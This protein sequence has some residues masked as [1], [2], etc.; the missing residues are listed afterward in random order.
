MP[1]NTGDFTHTLHNMTFSQNTLRIDG[2]ILWHIPITTDDFITNT[3]HCRR[4]YTRF[5]QLC[6]GPRN[7]LKIHGRVLWHKPVTTDDFITKY[8]SLP[9]TLYTFYTIM[10]KS[11]EYTKNT[12]SCRVP[13]DREKQGKQGKW[14]KQIPCR[15]KSGNLKI[16]FSIRENTGNLKIS[17]KYQGKHREFDFTKNK[18]YWKCCRSR[19]NQDRLQTLNIFSC[20][21]V[22]D[23]CMFFLKNFTLEITL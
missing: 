1:M 5:T 2:R 15:E 6:M 17:K 3:G 7:T 11:S 4:L 14:L 12:R 10:C 21:Q 18:F 19:V 23:D 20:M 9:T 13:T 16:L 8:R 22:I